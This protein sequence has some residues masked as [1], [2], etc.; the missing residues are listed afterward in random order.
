MR[1]R[2]FLLLAL[3][4]PACGMLVTSSLHAQFQ[5]QPPIAPKFGQPNLPQFPNPPIVNPPAFDPKFDGPDFP[6]GG[7]LDFFPLPQDNFPPAFMP[8]QVQP[9]QGSRMWV[10]IVA[11]IL[12]GMF[13]IAVITLVTLKACGAF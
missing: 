1:R 2:F 8:G 10:Y 9:E 11:A 3:T 7:D 6:V 4:L 13:L 12:G 5:P